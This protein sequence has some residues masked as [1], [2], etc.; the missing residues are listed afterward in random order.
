MR[1]FLHK[2]KVGG[3]VSQSGHFI[4]LAVEG[5]SDLMESLANEMR[6]REVERW[7][8]FLPEVLV[9]MLR[10]PPEMTHHFKFPDEL[11]LSEYCEA[12]FVADYRLFAVIFCD[13][14]HNSCIVRL[15]RCWV[16]FN[17]LIVREL[18]P[19]EVQ[20]RVFGGPENERL[21][22][23][24]FYTR[25]D[26]RVLEPGI[27]PII[28]DLR[29]EV[30]DDSRAFALSVCAGHAA[31][32]N[33][34]IEFAQFE[35]L[36]RYI[37]NVMLR[38]DLRDRDEAM[39]NGLAAKCMLPDEHLDWLTNNFVQQIVPLLET[40]RETVAKLMAWAVEH[41]TPVP[42][43]TNHRSA[44]LITALVNMVVNGQPRATLLPE[45]LNAVCVC[46][47]CRHVYESEQLKS[48][49][50]DLMTFGVKQLTDASPNSN[51]SRLFDSLTLIV[52]VR[53]GLEAEFAQLISLENRVKL[54]Q[55]HSASWRAFRIAG[56]MTEENHPNLSEAD[57]WPIMIYRVRYG[58]LTRT[59]RDIQDNGVNK[60]RPGWPAIFKYLVDQK[61]SLRPVL[62]KSAADL[63]FLF[64]E[65]GKVPWEYSS[66][67]VELLHQWDPRRLLEAIREVIKDKILMPE[68]LDLLLTTLREV[69]DWREPMPGIERQSDSDTIREIRELLGLPP[70]Q[71]PQQPV[72]PRVQTQGNDDDD[73][74]QR[75][76]ESCSSSTS[77]PSHNPAPM[78]QQPPVTSKPSSSSS[79][80]FRP[81]PGVS[82]F[83][84]QPSPS[85]SSGS[86]PPPGVPQ[87]RP[88]PGF[89]SGPVYQQPPVTS[90]P[91]PSS[92]S[93]SRPPPGVSPFRPPPSP[94]RPAPLPTASEKL[95]RAVG[96]L[97][98]TGE[99]AV[100]PLLD[101]LRRL[102]L[103]EWVEVLEPAEPL[104]GLVKLLV[105]PLQADAPERGLVAELLPILGRVMKEFGQRSQLR[106]PGGLG[107]SV[108]RLL[109]A[110]GFHV[111]FPTIQADLDEAR[112]LFST[113]LLEYG[114]RPWFATDDGDRWKLLCDYRRTTDHK[115]IR[116]K[117]LV[118]VDVDEDGWLGEVLFSHP[119]KS[120]DL[121]GFIR[122]ACAHLKEAGKDGAQAI[123]W[124]IQT[125]PDFKHDI[126]AKI[127]RDIDFAELGVPELSALLEASSVDIFLPR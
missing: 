115:D 35:D 124:M 60:L 104:A 63:L 116:I 118:D 24:L 96:Q 100:Q 89:Q 77:Q 57:V 91:S 103:D 42:N 79:S 94:P 53:N 11:E 37:F 19:N 111:H 85:S 119:L 117:L 59:I 58:D 69:P 33:F 122:Y 43:G 46:L 12:G 64:N 107:L 2:I 23:L 86:R 49:A 40:R 112:D 74:R 27:T 5:M 36:R 51:F 78:Y 3:D 105:Q 102:T 18:T 88:T 38:A 99:G 15:T 9:F 98:A 70:P 32:A 55:H 1:L 125:W 73:E 101:V 83:T 123:R 97:T 45:L 72:Q 108:V 56:E 92:S 84:S 26:S 109:F 47:E 127:P 31:T 25:T 66:S 4:E 30:A 126:I 67:V 22:H 50:H 75:D 17:D 87:P 21:A 65:K 110:N 48:W 16:E 39:I 71:P 120:A 106:R 90:N 44:G 62:L 93:G 34:V 29:R 80:G 76:D 68:L 13:N 121:P 41:A 54:S 52:N 6:T 114:E 82:Q 113:A 7:F 28:A 81:A 10:W 14:G 20:V 8:T 95:E 61:A